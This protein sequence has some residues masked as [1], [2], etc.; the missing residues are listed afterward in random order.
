MS[1]SENDQRNE[2]CSCNELRD[3]VQIEGF[4]SMKDY[5]DLLDRLKS[6]KTID[7]HLP[8]NYKHNFGE[9]CFKCLVCDKIW[10]IV[11]P[12]YPI[13]GYFGKLDWYL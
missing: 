9:S 12:D 6:D 4:K 10:I 2:T 7:I 3:L 1:G 11:Q 5:R 13:R 8:S